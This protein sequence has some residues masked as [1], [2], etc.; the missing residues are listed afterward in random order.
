MT[1]ELLVCPVDE[2]LDYYA[3]CVPTPVSVDAALTRMETLMPATAGTWL[4]SSKDESEKTVFMKLTPIIKAL[5]HVACVCKG[6]TQSRTLNFHY[7]DCGDIAIQG[8]MPGSS[9]SMDAYL[10]STVHDTPSEALTVSDIALVAEFEKTPAADKVYDPKAVNQSYAKVVNVAN[11]IMN[12]DPRRMW[13]YAFCRSQSSMEKW[14]SSRSYCVKSAKF[15]YKK[16]R[17]TFLQIFMSFLFATEAEMGFDPTVRR[18]LHDKEPRYIYTIT[19][20]NQSA[21]FFRTITTISNPSNSSITGRQTRVWEAEE[22]DES[23]ESAK[24]L[25]SNGKRVALK[26]AWLDEG[27]RT[28]SEI[29]DLIIGKLKEIAHDQLDWPT[30]YLGRCVTTALKDVPENLPFMKIEYPPYKCLAIKRYRVVYRDVGFALHASPDLKT[31]FDAI[32]YVLV[33]LTLLFLVGWVHRDISTGNIIVVKSGHSFRGLLSDFEYA[34]EVDRLDEGTPFFMALEVHLGYSI[35]IKTVHTPEEEATSPSGP[36]VSPPWMFQHHH[37][38]ESL[39]W[40]ALWLLLCRVKPVSSVNPNDL[41][42]DWLAGQIF[43]NTSVPSDLRELLFRL[44]GYWPITKVFHPNLGSDFH[45]KFTN[46]HFTLYEM[47]TRQSSPSRRDVERL[48]QHVWFC[49]GQII[50]AVRK[51]TGIELKDIHSDANTELKSTDRRAN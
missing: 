14:P 1:R 35:A 23:S 29:M 48:H 11:H 22:V 3:P 27:S 46:L 5:A 36:T 2:F 47:C 41:N 24:T 49:F 32:R 31:A 50:D 8:D 19:P 43:T 38:L 37:D 51:A 6:E 25:H 39:M 15:D 18:V 28:E 4:G 12:G 44:P 20:K 10:L 45:H 21:R 26:D 42:E 34:K 30:G 40:V 17:K 16:D 7:T 9:Y 13:T 33:A